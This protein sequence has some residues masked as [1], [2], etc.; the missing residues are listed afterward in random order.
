VN[1]INLILRFLLEVVAFLAPAFY[2]ASLTEGFLSIILPPLSALTLTLLWGIFA[3][4]NDPSRSG[5]T[6][7]KTPGWIRLVLELAIF[8][9][10]GWCLWEM[11]FRTSAFIYGAVVIIHNLM[12]YERNMWLIRQ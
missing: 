10:G 4:P 6:V 9:F 12:F 3:V 2:I 5:K 7:V 8:G 1:N 11:G